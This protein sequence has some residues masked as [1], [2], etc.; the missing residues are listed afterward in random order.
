M[1]ADYSLIPLMMYNTTMPNTNQSY[2]EWCIR[3]A[4]NSIV[5]AYTNQ[6]QY[7]EDITPDN[8][9]EVIRRPDVRFG[10]SNPLIDALGYRGL[11]V[12]QLAE[13]YYSN[14]TLFTGLFTAHFTPPFTR[15]R[16]PGTTSIV[17]PE[18]LNPQD[19]IAMRA[20]SVQLLYL[21]ESGGIDYCFLYLSNAKQYRMNYIELP[22]EINL[23]AL[24]HQAMYS[25]VQVAFEHQRF[26]NIGFD[27]DGKAIQ[28]GLTIPEN[29]P[30]R[31]TA[32]KFAE[33]I[34]SGPGKDVFDSL[35]HPIYSPPLTDHPASIPDELQP[36]LTANDTAP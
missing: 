8:W 25:K 22:V 35:W 26:A 6:S 21:L 3:F 36:F 11:M 4:G 12:A 18:L 30:N 10:V 7:R 33:F 13:E 9:Y 17:V 5:L 31:E 29:A 32:V 15:I 14:T 24:Q 1:V 2:T 28:Y 20:S 16:F 34:L 19:T 27:R 23:G